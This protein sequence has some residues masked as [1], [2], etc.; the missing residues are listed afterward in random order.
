MKKI[1][2]PL[3]MEICYFEE[4]DVLTDSYE[5]EDYEGPITPAVF[6]N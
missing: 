2:E 6:Y 1:F 3:K 4:R 5:P